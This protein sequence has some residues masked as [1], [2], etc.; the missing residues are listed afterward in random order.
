MLQFLLALTAVNSGPMLP[1]LL[2]VAGGRR[3]HPKDSHLPGEFLGLA[4]RC[5]PLSGQ[6]VLAAGGDGAAVLREAGR[7]SRL[8]TFTSHRAREESGESWL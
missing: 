6:T 5:D 3:P 2:L 1:R 8:R 7:V 4:G